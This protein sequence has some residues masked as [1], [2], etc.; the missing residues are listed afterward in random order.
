[1]LRADQIQHI[2]RV[3]M[4]KVCL[5]IIL[6]L[7]LLLSACTGGSR[8]SFIELREAF[9]ARGETV[10]GYEV[11]EIEQYDGMEFITVRI[12]LNSDDAAS[13]DDY[14]WFE[15][16]VLFFED[17]DEADAAYATNQASG[18]G[19]TCLQ[20]DRILIYWLEGDFFGDLYEEVF[21]NVL[22]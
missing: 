20:R 17:R 21:T 11:T 16:N 2:P 6:S 4:K 15:A 10:E 7:L 8:N 18:L 9:I 14:M 22:G 13:L 5:P 3:F 12:C 1:M 19:G